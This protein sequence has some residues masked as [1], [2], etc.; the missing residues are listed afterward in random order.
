LR[1][2][3][4]SGLASD[5]TFIGTWL[6]ER[7]PFLAELIKRGTPLTIR[8]DRWEK[9]PEWPVLRSHWRGPGLDSADYTAAIQAAKICIGMLS[10]QNRDL[11]TQRSMEIPAIGTV[12]CAERTSE[13]LALYKEGQEAVFWRDAAECAEVCKALL[14]DNSR[15][16]TIAQRG[17][18]RA[19]RNGNFNE[20]L[21]SLILSTLLD[22]AR[23][24]E[25]E[26]RR[27]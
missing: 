23:P 24:A 6:P 18:E 5:V 7:G 26:A 14:A 4:R 20:H 9:A 2:E 27:T 8:G 1:E 17:Y 21:V 10:K 3:E 13:H 16:E 11:H 15:R 22:R 25:L 12:L 19:L